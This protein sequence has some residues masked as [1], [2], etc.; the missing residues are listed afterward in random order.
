MKLSRHHAHVVTLGAA[1]A[2]I[3]LAIPG[4]ASAQRGAGGGGGFFNN[5]AMRLWGALDQGFD[6]F[7]G[8]LSLTETQT[9][10]VTGLVADFREENKNTLGRLSDMRNSMRSRLRGAGGGGGGGGGARAAG[11]GMRSMQEIRDLMRELT[12]ALETLHDEVTKLLDEKQVKTLAAIL[13]RPP[14]RG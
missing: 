3:T 12:P 1:V 11:G 5:P 13:E 10:A 8:E 2:A 9:E 4:T 6:D 14:R 7:A